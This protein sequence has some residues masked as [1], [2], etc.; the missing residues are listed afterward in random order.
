MSSSGSLV[1][2]EEK[3]PTQS[4]HRSGEGHLDSPLLLQQWERR[5]PVPGHTRHACVQRREHGHPSFAGYHGP[6]QRRGPGEPSGGRRWEPV[7]DE[8]LERSGPGPRQPRPERQHLRPVE[9]NGTYY[10]AS[11]NTLPFT[12]WVQVLH[13]TARQ[14]AFLGSRRYD[15]LSVRTTR[16]LAPRTLSTEAVHS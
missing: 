10:L 5:S 1:R 16:S 11:A 13:L 9:V 15:E 12:G 2:S 4:Y 7:A 3:Q 8:R 6:D 14:A